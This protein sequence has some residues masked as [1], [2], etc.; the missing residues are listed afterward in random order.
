MVHGLSDPDPNS[1]PERLVCYAKWSGLVHHDL[2][3]FNYENKNDA[4]PSKSQNDPMM[5]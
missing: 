5:D 3:R 4:I 2:A 1:E